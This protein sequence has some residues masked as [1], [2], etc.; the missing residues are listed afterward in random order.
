MECPYCHKPATK[1]TN[2]RVSKG[3]AQIWRRRK[4]LNCKE[5]FTTHEFIDLS[6][7]VVM[8]KSGNA[9][10]FSRMKL[11]S[12]IFYASGASKIPNRE[13]FIDSITRAVEKDILALRKKKITSEEIADVVLMQLKK[14]HVSTFLRF[15][16][17]CKDISSESHM[18][19][20]L[21]K[22]I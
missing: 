4:C 3:N 15:L 11:Y 20:E 7:I 2:S 9:E 5:L 10:M 6:H 14:K 21:A 1:V 13:L 17:N 22:Y 12:G 8:K 16:T 18:K 19:R